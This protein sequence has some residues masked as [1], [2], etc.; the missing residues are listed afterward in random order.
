M[1]VAVDAM[2]G[3]H[4]P[5]ATVEGAV[6]AAKELALDEVV[7]VG[8]QR[9]VERELSKYPRYGSKLTVAHAS[10]VVEMHASPSKV[11]RNKKDS[12]ISVA[13]ELVKDGRADA[14]ITAGNSGAAMA[15]SIKPAMPT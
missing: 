6:L 11:L 15:I 4:A 13:L 3:D 10:D 8:D 9:E 1:K 5:E 7:I 2:G 14:V 12:S